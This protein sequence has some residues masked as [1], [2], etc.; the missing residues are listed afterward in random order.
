MY[1]CMYYIIII[2]VII[3]CEDD[4]ILIIIFFGM[5]QANA[6]PTPPATSSRPASSTFIPPFGRRVIMQVSPMNFGVAP[7]AVLP[8]Q[9]RRVLQRGGE[10]DEFDL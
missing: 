1:V 2:V 8:V 10:K 5:S 9:L 4:N 7:L 6:A 3:F